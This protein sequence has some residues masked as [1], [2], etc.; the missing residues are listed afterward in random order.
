M[1]D[2]D[3]LNRVDLNFFEL[4][5]G[6]LFDAVKAPAVGELENAEPC[7]KRSLVDRVSPVHRQNHDQTENDGLTH[8]KRPRG[9]VQNLHS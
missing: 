8:C 6:Q 4:P 5:H 1:V 9:T 7:L 3:L 2:G